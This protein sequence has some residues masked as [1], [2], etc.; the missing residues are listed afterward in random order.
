MKHLRS[1]SIPEEYPASLSISQRSGTTAS[2]A[3]QDNARA[4]PPVYNPS[5]ETSQSLPTPSP[6]LGTATFDFSLPREE[7]T[8]TKRWYGL[9][10]HERTLFVFSSITVLVTVISL[11]VLL[12]KVP[13]GRKDVGKKIFLGGILIVIVAS[14]TG[15]VAV[16]RNMGEV[17]F[18]VTMVIALGIFLNSFLDILT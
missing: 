8:M 3:Q 6:E 16:R 7:D 12:K 1:N 10:P 9:L 17:L 5:S 4:D 11:F 15:M 14:G 18:T 13:K 2:G